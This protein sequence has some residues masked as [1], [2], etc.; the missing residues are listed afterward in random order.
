MKLK[1][2]K[3]N[4]KAEAEVVGELVWEHD[5]IAV[6]H[7]TAGRPSRILEEIHSQI[8]ESSRQAA[9]ASMEKLEIRYSGGYCWVRYER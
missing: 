6:L 3:R 4:R 7:T 1:V 8:D 9:A 5:H 2:V